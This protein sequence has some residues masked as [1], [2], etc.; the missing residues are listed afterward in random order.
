MGFNVVAG[1]FVFG[2]AVVI[3]AGTAFRF[4]RGRIRARGARLKM[5]ASLS[6]VGALMTMGL[7]QLSDGTRSVVRIAGLTLLLLAFVA[8]YAYFSVRAGQA[9]REARLR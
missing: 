4:A 2:V 8:L 3:A 5:W 6:S 9:A 7:E 1:C